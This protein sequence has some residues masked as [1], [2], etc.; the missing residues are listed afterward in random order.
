MEKLVPFG[1]EQRIAARTAGQNPDTTAANRLD[2][3]G[4]SNSHTF[5]HHRARS[6]I[7]ATACTLPSGA[8]RDSGTKV[9]Q[10]LGMHR[11]VVLGE[12]IDEATKRNRLVQYERAR[13]T[14]VALLRRG[15]SSGAEMI[16]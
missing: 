13:R 4:L 9:Q 16:A 7:G 2:H 10:L 12:T 14:P 3:P 6:T 8:P 11:H 1:D 5:A 15:P